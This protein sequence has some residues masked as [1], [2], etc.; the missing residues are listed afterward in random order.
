MVFVMIFMKIDQLVYAILKCITDSGKG[1][2]ERT[3]KL[4]D[5]VPSKNFWFF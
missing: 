1:H 4:A 2:T 3:E 5:N